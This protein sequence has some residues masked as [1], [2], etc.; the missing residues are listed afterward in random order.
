MT[1]DQ[2]NDLTE[3][4]I[5]C[6][7]AVH[8]RLG[9]GKKEAL[10]EEALQKSL[11]KQ[12]VACERQVPLP[13]E[14]G[15][16]TLDCGYRMDLVVEGVIVI[17]LKTVAVLL[18]IHDAQLLTYLKLSGHK[19]GLLINF[20]SLML[21][22]GIRRRVHGLGMEIVPA[23]PWTSRSLV[24]GPL[25]GVISAA[26]M[27]HSALGP[28]LM[29]STYTVCMTH[30]LEKRLGAK[31]SK[32]VQVHQNL[33]RPVELDGIQLDQPLEVELALEL[34]NGQFVPLLIL[35]VDSI[36]PL[37]EARLRSEIRLAGWQEGLILNFNADSMRDGIRHVSLTRP[38]SHFITSSEP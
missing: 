26:M 36:T 13:V 10:Y 29:R 20:H 14:Y 7:I 19:V 22:D 3:R 16:T 8:R 23:P 38:Q 30:E 28:G 18:P 25:A 31:A 2:Y 24:S 37:H 12:G 34:E 6:A 5:G 1:E 15:G 32:V 9:P 11:R 33:Q 4:V 35:S 27:V 17:E 21:K